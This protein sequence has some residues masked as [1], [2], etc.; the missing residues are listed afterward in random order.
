M[1]WFDILKNQITS[2]KGKQF[3]LDFNQPMIE[4]EKCKEKLRAVLNQVA[5]INSIEGFEK[6]ID[7]K[8][9]QRHRKMFK[10]KDDSQFRVRI[11]TADRLLDEVPEEVCCA[12]IELYKALSKNTESPYES[13][14]DIPGYLIY[15]T[16]SFDYHYDGTD[17]ETTLNIHSR[18]SW[19]GNF[20]IKINCTYRMDYPDLEKNRDKVKE[21]IELCEKLTQEYV[22][23]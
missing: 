14:K 16:R 11:R 7:K 20:L 18:G 13:S 2:A 22:K 10:S 3:Q 6:R 19:E 8:T 21:T 15:A 4:E 17:V 5:S 12:L 9:A 1:N 23:L